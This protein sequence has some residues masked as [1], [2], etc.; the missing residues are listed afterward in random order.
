MSI[1]RPRACSESF[2]V[3]AITRKLNADE[4]SADIEASSEAP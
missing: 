4:L 1:A 2:T 3:P